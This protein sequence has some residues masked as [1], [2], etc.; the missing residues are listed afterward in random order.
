MRCVLRRVEGVSHFDLNGCCVQTIGSRGQ[1]RHCIP[2]QR[3][4][5][6]AVVVLYAN[7]DTNIHTENREGDRVNEGG[8]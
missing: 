6:A 4:T 1:Q 5:R 8:V 7:L 2:L 3:T